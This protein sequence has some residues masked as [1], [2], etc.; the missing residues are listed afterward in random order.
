MV[1]VVKLSLLGVRFMFPWVIRGA[2]FTLKM[3]LIAV[4]SL[5]MGVPKA[6]QRI[7]DEWLDRAIRA[8]FP[9]L[10]ATSLYKAVYTA[11]FLVIVA[12]WVI[13]AFVT[14]ALIT[15]II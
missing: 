13:F 14:V 2:V 7:A 11:A 15:W 12:S 8:G 6:C 1:H 9:S 3:V 4:A 10:Y 5:W